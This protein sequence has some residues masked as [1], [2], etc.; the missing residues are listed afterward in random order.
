MI[1]LASLAEKNLL[2]M[3]FLDKK[4][5]LFVI[6]NAY[7]GQNRLNKNKKKLGNFIIILKKAT[8]HRK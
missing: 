3:Y 6:L 7:K 4:A 8:F 2:R 5:E 1:D